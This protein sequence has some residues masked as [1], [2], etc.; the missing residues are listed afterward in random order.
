VK[1]RAT[2]AKALVLTELDPAQVPLASIERDPAINCRVGGVHEQIATEYAE[3]L[4]NGVQLPPVIVFRD[5]DGKLWLAD[6]FHRCRAAELAELETVVVEE[7]AGERRDALLYAAG[8]NASHGARRTNDDKRKAVV[9]LLGDEEWRAK[10]DRWIA[11]Q[12]AVS[13]E[14]V[15]RCRPQLSSVD[16]SSAR[17]GRDGKQRSSAKRSKRASFSPARAAKQ[18]ERDLDRVTRRW[19]R[20]ASV[21]PLLAAVRA[22]L[23]KLELQLGSSK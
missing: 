14:F 21:E 1:A 13:H 4:R 20:T 17:L 2:A 15:R 8:A 19:P 12:C 16:S 22:L 7:R 9:T 11:E 3:A 18:V 23:Q 5:A 10:S 6:G